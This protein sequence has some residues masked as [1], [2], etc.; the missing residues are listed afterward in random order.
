M[1]KFRGCEALRIWHGG[2]EPLPI[3]GGLCGGTLLESFGTLL[4]SNLRPPA[5]AEGVGNN[6]NRRTLG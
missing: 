2:A 3:C 6:S 5:G 4:E 1:R